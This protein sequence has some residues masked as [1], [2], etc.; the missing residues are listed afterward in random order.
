MP[1]T[2]PHGNV[3][4]FG[5]EGDL[6]H[7]PA[8][9]LQTALTQGYS[10]ATPDDVSNFNLQ[11]QYGSAGQ[12]AI[13]GIEGAAKSLTFGAS[14][15]VER[16]LGVP[17][18]DILGR[19]QANPWAH[20][21][22]ELG[23]LAAGMVTGSTEARALKAGAEG[24][25]GLVGLG[26]GSIAARIGT[27]AVK[28]ATEMA[29]IQA[30]DEVS[31]AFLMDPN[32]SME[33]ALTHVGLAGLL[34]GGLGAGTSAGSEALFK[35]VNEAKLGSLLGAIRNKVT[36]VA[37]ADTASDM[38]KQAGIE[39]SPELRAALSG[40][41]ASTDIAQSL[42]ESDT[43]A[44]EAMRQGI[45]DLK[46]QAHESIL[47]AFGRTAEDVADADVSAY[48]AGSK[49]KS[50]LLSD[51]KAK[52]DE[53]ESRFAP[54]EEK[55]KGSPVPEGFHTEVQ[56][57][58]GKIALENSYSLREASPE[59][60]EL[61]RVIKDLPNVKTLEDLRN[62]QSQVRSDLSNKRLFTL[63]K[64]VMGALRDGETSAL[65]S[66]LGKEAPDMVGALKAAREGYKGVMGQ[67]E[68][69]NEALHVG[70]FKGLNGF[71]KALGDM[72]EERILSRLGQTNNVGLTAFLSQQFPQVA[73]FIR[74][75][76]VDSLLQKAVRAPGADQG[77]NSRA[78][79]RML[80]KMSPEQRAFLLPEG[81]QA[82]LDAAQGLLKKLPERLNPSGTARA[83]DAIWKHMPG[84]ISGLIAAMAGHNI[85]LGFLLGEI[86]RYVGREVPDAAKLSLLRFLGTEGPIDAAGFRSLHGI[87]ERL[88]K[89]H[90]L[91]DK[92]VQGVFKSA[93]DVLP[94]KALPTDKHREK[95]E[96]FIKVAQEDPEALHTLAENAGTYA[97]QHG[98]AAGAIAGRALSYLL[99]QRPNTQPMDALGPDRTPTA[100]ER[101]AY[102]RA[103]DIA[104]QPLVV[105]KA[106]KDGSITPQDVTALDS[107]Y[108]SLYASLKTKA[109][110]YMVEAKAK[111]VLI[112]Y[113]TRIGLSL[114]LGMP[115]ESSITPQNIAANQAQPTQAAPQ[116]GSKPPQSAYKGLS[117]LAQGEATSSQTREQGRSK[118]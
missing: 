46:R 42:R 37:G 68:Q 66:V 40:E 35:A 38:A 114:F 10:E 77:M 11:Q 39:L 43:G 34:G 78:L 65:D 6:G 83:L 109:I 22:G 36:G 93:E 29:M 16:A 2:I 5:P 103:L 84:G 62:F 116:Q 76:Q 58:L 75:H 17:A 60:M 99:S 23:G 56:E 32:Q 25:A 47:G 95:L 59:M 55:F 51:L 108:P 31:K 20:G 21:L 63:S 45:D 112:P 69:L 53:F 97:P 85:G 1:L 87:V 86:G 48:Q 52:A 28:Q 94:E 74:S 101:A 111:G 19:E 18:Q 102:N 14:S 73:D 106:A 71:V 81:A 98:I 4:V 49:V 105:L 96:N 117:G 89:G 57:K 107:M 41:K 79:F 72:G 54:I 118:A 8:E 64:Q 9:Q 88:Y 82:R 27:Q 92:A 70:K 3:P 13:S 90:A 7:I 30:G 104:Q 44:G 113:R 26:E 91:V 33:T 15:G 61:N 50:A 80:D 110:G 100:F 24:A 115:L 12:Q 67:V